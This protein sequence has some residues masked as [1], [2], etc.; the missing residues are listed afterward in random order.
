M[1]K[2]YKLIFTGTMGAGKTTAISTISEFAPVRTEV[3]SSEKLSDDKTTT[4]AA[5]DY[6][7]VMLPD[8]DVLR[9]YGTPGQSRFN[10]M[11][12]ILS[13]GALGVVL[14]VDNR[15]PDPVA[16]FREYLDAFREI[17]K[18][19]RAVVGICRQDTHPLPDVEAFCVAADAMG[20]DTPIISVDVRSRD[21]VLLLVDIL[22]NQIEAAEA[23]SSSETVVLD[24]T[25]MRYA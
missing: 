6:G 10:F 5:L 19:S 17:V 25:S 22:F 4:T 21:D 2:E 23:D 15:R 14:L 20:L 16:D 12:N 1:A 24:D 9:L 18:G 8:G 13:N 3:A 7:E 11:W